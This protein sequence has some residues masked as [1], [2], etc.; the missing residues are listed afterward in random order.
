[1]AGAPVTTASSKLLQRL[2][3]MM[4]GSLGETLGALIN[5]QIVARPGELR[6]VDAD[7]HVRAL[8]KPAAVARGALDKAFAGRTFATAFDMVDALAMAGLLMLTPQEVVEQRRAAGVLDGEDAEAFQELGNV[9]YSGIGNVLREHVAECD[10][11]QRDHGVVRPG[12]DKDG[13]LGAG[14]LV[15]CDFALKV[16]AYPATEGAFVLDLATAEAWNKGA[17]ARVGAEAAAAPAAPTPEA[18]PPPAAAAGPDEPFESIPEAPIRG[19]LAAFVCDPKALDLVRRSCRRVGLELATHN[20][21]E[22][23]NPASHRDEI[24]VIDVPG[25]EE[26][27]IDWC[28]RVKEYQ[29]NVRIVLLLHRPSRQSVA[30][31]F[32]AKADVIL[33]VPCAEAQLS[34]RLSALLETPAAP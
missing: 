7:E 15:V 19:R 8:D 20:R 25:N 16:G 24:V 22:V 33:G 23:P 1:M 4:A 11:R 10:V 12:L 29:P 27:R 31:C 18:P 28:R 5:T 26:R 34:Q 17:L 14:D 32:A 6:I 9:L 3:A 21:V 13:L 30:Q 2:F